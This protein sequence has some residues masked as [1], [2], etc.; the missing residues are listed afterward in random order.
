MAFADDVKRLLAMFPGIAAYAAEVDK[1]GS[2]EQAASE[3][4]SRLAKAKKDF[5]EQAQ[6]LDKEHAKHLD[7]LKEV[8]SRTAKT[9]E[10][11][12]KTMD[13]AQMQADRIIAAAHT[14]GEKILAGAKSA[15]ESYVGALNEIRAKIAAAKE[16]LQAIQA[17]QSQERDRLR[18][19]AARHQHFK[20]SIDELKARL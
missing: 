17:E 14:E 16:E 10:N 15:A 3:A 6:A 2:L 13:N 9:R 1:V 11:I 19:V 20:N 18:E 12:S 5:D 8:Q 4:E 7:V